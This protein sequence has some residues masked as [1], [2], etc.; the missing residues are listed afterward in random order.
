VNLLLKGQQKTPHQRTQ[1]SKPAIGNHPRAD[2][3]QTGED[4]SDDAAAAAA[5]FVEERHAT[6]QHMDVD[7]DEHEM[8]R[9]L[10]VAHNDYQSRMVAVLDSRNKRDL[11]A[12]ESITRVSFFVVVCRTCVSSDSCLAPFSMLECFG[13]LWH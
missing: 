11:A 13:T 5:S 8:E 1:S 3:G 9:R 7:E 12:R 2:T 10:S 6:E 4:D